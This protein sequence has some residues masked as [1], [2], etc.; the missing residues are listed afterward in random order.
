[1]LLGTSAEASF[2]VTLYDNSFTRKWVEELRWCLSHC[3]ID[4]I[5]VFSSGYSLQKSADILAKSC[6]TINRYLKNFI[7]IR[8][9][10]PNQS[11]EYFN[12]LHTKF[13]KLSGDFGKPTRLFSVASTELREAIRYLNF[14]IH[15][16]ETKKEKF[17]NFYISFNKDQYRRHSLTDEDYEFFQFNFPKGTLFLHYVEL[18]KEFFDLYQNNLP[19][20]Y[21]G[22]KNLHFFS[23]EASITF[24]EY[25][26]FDDQNYL[27]WLQN[28]GINPYNKLLGHGKIPLG[29]INDL[30]KTEKIIK[31]H[32][33][34]HS[35]LITE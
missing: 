31:E 22:F 18:G 3:D 10:I 7:E 30:S 33:H 29:I 34:L 23:G 24:D 6:E 20:D 17:S 26:A 27:K 4:Q 1:M 35:I 25:N 5:E 19:I 14:F 9:N 12:Y 13:E 11:Q 2:N 15:R 21:I 32:Q 8:E 28:Q 16:V